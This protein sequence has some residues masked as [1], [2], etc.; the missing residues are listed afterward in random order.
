MARAQQ[1]HDE[2][3]YLLASEIV[4]KLVQANRRTNP[5]RTLADIFEQIDY[6]QRHAFSSQEGGRNH[7]PR[8][9]VFSAAP[10]G[11]RSRRHLTDQ[12]KGCASMTTN[13]VS[14]FNGPGPGG[15]PGLRNRLS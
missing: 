15:P 13:A 9:V 14:N 6:Q 7:S 2:G 1:L 11:G 5:P 8:R 12:W 10:A 4:N 3:K